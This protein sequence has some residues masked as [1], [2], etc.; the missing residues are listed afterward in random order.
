M[1]EEDLIREVV[2][3]TCAYDGK[4]AMDFKYV[5]LKLISINMKLIPLSINVNE[6]NDHPA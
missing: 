6:Q 5:S 4:H 3:H 2:S 1:S